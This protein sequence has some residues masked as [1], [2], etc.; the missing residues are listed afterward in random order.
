MNHL[1]AQQKISEELLYYVWRLKNFNHRKLTTT[2]GKVIQIMDTGIRNH[3]SGPDFLHAKIK[4]GD[5]IWAGHV[6][7]HV[8]S[9]DWTKHQHQHDPAFQN[10]ILHVVYE[11]DVKINLPNGEELACL[12]LKQRIDDAIVMNYRL[13]MENALWIPCAKNERK[14]SPPALQAWY[15]RTLVERLGAK[16]LKLHQVLQDTEYDWEEAFYRLLGRNFGFSVNADAF[17]ALLIALPRKILVKHKNRLFQLEALLFGQAGFL[18]EDFVDEYPRELQTEYRFLQKKYALN[19]IP[20]HYWKFMRMR[21]ANFPTIRI[22]QFAILFF[23]TV[24]LFSKMLAAQSIKEVYIMF[25]S[26][27]SAYW[28]THYT[29]DQESEKKPKKLGKSSID[30]LVINTVVPFLFHYGQVQMR[31]NLQDKSLRFLDELQ[32]E[33]NQ[34][35]KNFKALNFKVSSAFDTQALLQLKKDYCD[36]KRCLEC[37]IGNSIL[38]T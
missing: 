37:A 17:E 21:P 13:L 18:E 19:P 23:K 10:V 32:P 35:I 11:E 3:D 30:L 1:N 31:E 5:R 33:N 24:H 28:K 27:V 34:V 15:E 26:D 6:E 12:P 7:M 29:F 25:Q 16:T 14:I 22:A 2:T 9:S 36:A 4:I 8:V 20:K 38:K